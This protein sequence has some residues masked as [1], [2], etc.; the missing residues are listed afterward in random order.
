MQEAGTYDYERDSQ[1]N[2]PGYRIP[3]TAPDEQIDAAVK[4][5]NEA[6]R[7]V[8]LAGHGVI[9]SRAFDELKELA[10]KA[11]IPVVTTLLGYLRLSRKPSAPCRLPRY[12]RRSVREFGP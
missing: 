6:E 1:I 12:A 7:P 9:I 2:L 3:T 10:E 5:I 8:F 11:Q 4:L